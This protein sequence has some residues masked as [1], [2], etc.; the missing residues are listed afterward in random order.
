[1]TAK[2]L[3]EGLK[4]DGSGVER[5]FATYAPFA[6]TERLLMALGKAGADRQV[7]H[8]VIRSMRWPP[9]PKSARGAPIR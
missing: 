8:E 9:G 1:M 6:A 2:K 4:I 3:I 5:N 7:M